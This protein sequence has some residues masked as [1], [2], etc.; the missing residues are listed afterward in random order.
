MI[1]TP[2]S[3][4]IRD[5]RIGESSGVRAE[6]L[7][8]STIYGDYYQD[9]EPERFKRGSL[10]PPLLLETGLIIESMFEE[11]LT[12]RFLANPQNNEQIERPG[13]FTA[14]GHFDGHPYTIHYNPDLLIFN[15]VLR[16]G[17]IKAT[18]LSSKIPGEWIASPEA[19]TEHI[20]D[21]REAFAN[22]KLNKYW[23]QMLLYMKFLKTRF[24]RL[25]VFFI[26]G[27]YD[28]PFISQLIAI[29]VEFSQDEIDTEFAVL[30]YHAISKK[31]I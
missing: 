26:A 27:N 6:G 24:G 31:M 19:I 12:R 23:S 16:L 4:D 9:A 28:R 22:P 10:P 5:F 17:E 30:M 18:W 3:F 29:D 14:T 11:G 8:A 1:L 20:E 25:Y 15:G 13:E 2:Q 7:H 21:I